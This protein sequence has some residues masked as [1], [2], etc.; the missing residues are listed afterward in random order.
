[1]GGGQSL[2]EKIEHINSLPRGDKNTPESL[3]GYA[4]AHGL[5]AAKETGRGTKTNRELIDMLIKQAQKDSG[6]ERPLGGYKHLTEMTAEDVDGKQCVWKVNTTQL[7][8][9]CNR[10]GLGH[11]R[12][13]PS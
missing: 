6:C 13:G 10:I 8:C 11:Q 12:P 7:A 3:I 5:S 2:E 4:H 1:M 9:L